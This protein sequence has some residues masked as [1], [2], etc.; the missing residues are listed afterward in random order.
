[1]GFLESSSFFL[2][3]HFR[4]TSFVKKWRCPLDLNGT[5]INFLKCL[6]QW[7]K[8]INRH[9]DHISFPQNCPMFFSST[10]H[11]PLSIFLTHGGE[12]ISFHLE[13]CCVSFWRWWLCGLVH[14]G[15]WLKRGFSPGEDKGKEK[16][17]ESGDKMK[18]SFQQGHAVYVSLSK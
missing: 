15:S 11:L 5:C 13:R 12:K 7:R 17:G 14:Y 2:L 1:M 10:P 3:S 16:E 8:I 6:I 9:H 18:C 4:F